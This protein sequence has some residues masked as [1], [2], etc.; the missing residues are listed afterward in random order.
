MNDEELNERRRP[1]AINVNHFAGLL[2]PVHC[3]TRGDR[4]SFDHEGFDR[5]LLL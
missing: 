5:F 1:L 2:V 4:T 3:A